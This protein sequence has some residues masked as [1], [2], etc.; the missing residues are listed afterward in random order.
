M[1]GLRERLEEF[2]GKR[3]RG[4]RLGLD[5][6][7]EAMIRHLCETIGDQNPVYTD[8][9]A[10][11][12]SV[13]G[14]IVAPPASLQVWTMSGFHP[15]VDPND[16][17]PSLT[18]IMTDEG[19]TGVVATNCE[20]EYRRYL[21]PGDHLTMVSEV[22]DIV[23]PKTTALGEGYFITTLETYTDQQGEVVGT[24]RFRLFRY[25]PAKK[26]ST[27][28]DAGATAGKQAPPT[29]PRPSTNQDNQFWWDGIAAGE[30]RIQRCAS[31]ERL[32]HPAQPACAACGSLE[33]D[34]IVTSGRGEV[35]S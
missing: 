27:P 32:R 31:C 5:P 8:A 23:G 30:L 35:Y 24:M 34:W 19:Y 11:A 14:G 16:R 1:S 28:A 20:Q 6:V 12:A 4:P 10:A 3:Y 22:E 7:N 13:H 9:E 17:Q 26:T 18:K 15:A 33:W 29:R 21:R 25:I 2:V